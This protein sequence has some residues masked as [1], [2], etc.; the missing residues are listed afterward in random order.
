MKRSELKSLLAVCV[1]MLVINLPVMG[2]NAPLG[3]V[4]PRSGSSQVNGTDLFLETTVFSGDS[5]ATEAESLALIELPH[6]EQIHVGPSSSA[7]LTTVEDSLVVGLRNGIVRTKSSTIAVD[8]RGLVV[9]PVE[10]ATYDVAIENNA[11]YVRAHNGS[12][13]VNGRNQSFVVPAEKTMKFE[14]AAN[15]AP[16]AVGIGADSMTPGQAAAI[17]LAISLGVTLGVVLPILLSEIDDAE[18]D[19]CIR[20][21][22]AVSPTASTSVCG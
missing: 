8:A 14:L 13:E 16:G 12:V 5:V 21:I 22:Q 15:T 9:R 17:T 3:K 19:A 1:C 11:V 20:A 18:R 4:L 10:A 6:G 2:A 7:T